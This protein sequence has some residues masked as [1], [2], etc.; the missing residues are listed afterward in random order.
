MRNGAEEI[1]RQEGGDKERGLRK[2]GMK[3]WELEEKGVG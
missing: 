2:R 1:G 3:G